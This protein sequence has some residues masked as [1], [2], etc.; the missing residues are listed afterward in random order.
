MGLAIGATLLVEGGPWKSRAAAA[1]TVVGLE[2]VLESGGFFDGEGK[3][4]RE[5]RDARMKRDKGHGKRGEREREEERRGRRYVERDDWERE[6]ERNGGGG[7]EWRNIDEWRRS[8]PRAETAH[9][10]AYVVEEDEDEDDDDYDRR[11]SGTRTS[12]RGYEH[13]SRRIYDEHDNEDEHEYDRQWSGTRTRTPRD[14]DERAGYD[15]ASR[16][17]RNG[18]A[19]ANERFD[20]EYEIEEV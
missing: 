10:R 15:G 7:G 1:A 12:R 13:T 3:E 19:N 6:E 18:T 2:T 8:V 11:R 17:R 9:R 20:A 16:R 5:D 14:R 4:R